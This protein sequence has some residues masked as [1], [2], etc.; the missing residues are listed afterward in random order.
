MSATKPALLI[1]LDGTLI[2]SAPDLAV[3][4]NKLLVEEGRSALSEAEVTAMVGHG[5]RRLVTRAFAATGPAA[6][7]D[8]LPG[9]QARFLAHYVAEP[10]AR[11]R[12]Y[13]GVET[14]LRAL[15]DTGHPMA[16][17]TNKPEGPSRLILEAL[18]LDRY[19]GA[20]VGGDTLPRRKPD[21]S[22]AHET[23]RQLGTTAENA[24]FVGDS[25][26]DYDT[27]RA[28]GLPVVLVT[29]GY[30]DGLVEGLAAD[31]HIHAFDDLP[32]VLAENGWGSGPA[33]IDRNRL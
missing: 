21:P 32:R 26:T 33:P 29:Y 25:V 15:Q 2:H 19:F 9:L 13:L 1:D 11:T 3:A 10:T 22:M 7:E 30:G 4:V 16:V 24:V 12:P 31:A 5:A 6:A 17:C 28:A 8:A 23:L 18:A 20:V 14:A 27:A